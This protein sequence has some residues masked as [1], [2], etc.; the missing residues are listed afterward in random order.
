MKTAVEVNGASGPGDIFVTWTPVPATVHLS[1]ATGAVGPVGV[2]LRNAAPATTG[3]VVFGS[4]RNAT[5]AAQINLTLPV[6]GSTVPLFVAGQ[7]QAPSSAIDDVT[8]EVVDAGTNQVLSTTTLMVRI[9]KNAMDVSTPERDRFIA[10]MAALNNKGSGRFAGFRLVHFAKGIDEAHFAPGFLPWHRAFLLDLERELQ[11]LDSSVA[12]PYWRF[13]EPAPKVFSQAFMGIT[14]PVTGAV[15]LSADNPLQLWKSDGVQGIDRRPLFNSQ[16]MPA[17]DNVNVPQPDPVMDETSTLQLGGAADLFRLFT[18]MEANPHGSAH[19]SF[20]GFLPSLQM[21]VRDPLFFMLHGNVD[22]LWAKWQWFNGRFDR[23]TTSSFSAQGAAGP[24]NPVRI[25]HNL[26]DTM[27]PWNGITGAPRPSTAPGG[28]FPPSAL[29]TAPGLT[30]TV[31]DL[32][33][34]QGVLDPADRLGFDYDDVP[35]EV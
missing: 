20:T 23:T 14:D 30:P 10:A 12:L 15:R 17:S 16:T 34:F 18:G 19:M 26:L 6:D 32:I 25:G 28:D 27:W 21:A 13:D 31:G 9:R 22:R 1:D 8:I 3:H 29:A 2:V 4:A 35:F 7:F 33:D 11:L 5:N 24:A